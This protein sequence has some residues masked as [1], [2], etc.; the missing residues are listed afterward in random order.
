MSW[1]LRVIFLTY[2]WIF[3]TGNLPRE[4]SVILLNT[5]SRGK[6]AIYPGKSAPCNR[7]Y[8]FQI[9]GHERA[10]DNVPPKKAFPDPEKY[11]LKSVAVNNASV[12]FGKISLGCDMQTTGFSNEGFH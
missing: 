9:S 3:N 8:W 6:R 4:T 1:A 5:V 2:P 7:T 12:S 11:E 10:S